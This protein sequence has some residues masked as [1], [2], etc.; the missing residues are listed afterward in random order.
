LLRIL[1]SVSTYMQLHRLLEK[2]C[3]FEVAEEKCLCLQIMQIKQ[4]QQYK[5]KP[6]PLPALLLSDECHI[7]HAVMS[8]QPEMAL[9]QQH[10]SSHL[11][12]TKHFMEAETL[13]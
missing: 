12:S 13:S 9:L 8:R 4:Q 6:I 11:H 2:G 5:T 7:M 1:Q 10:F 3:I